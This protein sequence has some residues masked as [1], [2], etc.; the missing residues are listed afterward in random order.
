MTDPRAIAVA[1][2]RTRFPLEP[3]A[4]L[5]DVELGRAGGSREGQAPRGIPYIAEL[6]GVSLSTAK[7]WHSEGLTEP[8]ADRVA[9]SVLNRMPD[10]IWPEYGD[11][12][13][14]DEPTVVVA[15]L[16]DEVA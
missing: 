6:C 16:F 14:I 9:C 11:L 8:E 2:Q 5:L 3:L 15:S 7:R 13:V 1:N 12:P 10:S 4:A